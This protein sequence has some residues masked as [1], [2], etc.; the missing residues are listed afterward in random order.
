[1]HLGELLSQLRSARGEFSAVSSCTP[2]VDT[3]KD[4]ESDPGI[5]THTH[6]ASA[7]RLLMDFK[8]S[9]YILLMHFLKTS[10]DRPAHAQGISSTRGNVSEIT[11]Q[12]AN[13]FKS[14]DWHRGALD[15]HHF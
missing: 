12:F 10:S 14:R 13:I 1:M 8:R 6:S 4:I 11:I 9:A 3:E 5:S 7:T 15:L 2:L